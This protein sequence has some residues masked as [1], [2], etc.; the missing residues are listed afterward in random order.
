MAPYPRQTR[1]DARYAQQVQFQSQQTSLTPVWLRAGVVRGRARKNL[2]ADAAIPAVRPAGTPRPGTFFFCQGRSTGSRVVASV[3]PSRNPAVPVT[4]DWTRLAAYSCGGS[5]GLARIMDRGAPASLLALGVAT[6]ETL[7]TIF[8]SHSTFGV[9]KSFWNPD[10]NARNP[11]AGRNTGLPKLP[12]ADLP[13][14]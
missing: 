11:Q 8:S 13:D 5:A 9:N 3:R 2:A 6:R 4:L 12:P 10:T 14:P 1:T 7:A